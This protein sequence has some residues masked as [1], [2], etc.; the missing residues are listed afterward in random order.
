MPLEKLYLTRKIVGAYKLT[1][2]AVKHKKRK[3]KTPYLVA[4]GKEMEEK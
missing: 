2:A 4:Y 3:N 1:T